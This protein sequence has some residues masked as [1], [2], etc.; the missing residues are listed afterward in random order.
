MNRAYSL[1]TVKSVADDQRIITGIATTPSVDRM[2]DVVDP[3]GIQFRNPMPL[4]HN[5]RTDQPV[6]T[7]T[8]RT[9]TA[10]GIQFEA[11]LPRSTNPAR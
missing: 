1:L 5:H 4:L 8:F 6:G 11:R 2:Q 7:V 9:P 10:K 3:M